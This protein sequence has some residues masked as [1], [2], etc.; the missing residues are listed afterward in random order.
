MN[1]SHYTFREYFL[2]RDMPTGCTSGEKQWEGLA[3]MGCAPYG[4]LPAPG[5]CRAWYRSNATSVRAH[6]LGHNL[7]A[8]HAAGSTSTIRSLLKGEHV[9][10]YTEYGDPTA[11]MG[12]LGGL[13]EWTAPTRFALGLLP[14]SRVKQLDASGTSSPIPLLG[15]DT[16]LNDTVGGQVAAELVCP[17]CS[18]KIAQYNE[19]K[20]LP[21]GVLFISYRDARHSGGIKVPIEYQS[22]VYVHFLRNYTG[23]YG[24]GTELW[25]T[26][27]AGE[28]IE[29]EKAGVTILACDTGADQAKVAV[30]KEPQSQCPGAGA[31]LKNPPPPKC[32][33]TAARFEVVLY[34]MHYAFDSAWDIRDGPASQP[35]ASGPNTSLAD[36]NVQFAANP[37]RG[38]G[39]YKRYVRETWICP[40][41]HT[42][43][44]YDFDGNGT[45]GANIRL[46]EMTTK[47]T[48]LY[49][50]ADAGK[51]RV[52]HN[53]SRTTSLTFTTYS[54]EQYNSSDFRPPFPTPAPKP[55]SIYPIF[56]GRI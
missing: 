4:S 19:R 43:N 50:E 42:L 10:H 12:N 14:G 36:E 28:S 5:S 16:P 53:K 8:G 7:G 46:I 33:S 51:G 26:L 20:D 30:G 25:A 24:R 32:N 44:I 29:V 52:G 21:G 49:L 3:E 39:D 2:P 34:T 22:K 56:S 48:I 1:T 27:G 13:R 31:L 23:S 37:R 54:P 6:E 47:K 55:E 9:A 18:S 35:I 38:Y 45:H 17:S 11:V 15:L 41:V 40:G